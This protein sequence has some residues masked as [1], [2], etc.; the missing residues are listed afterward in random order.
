M[1]QVGVLGIIV[2]SCLVFFVALVFLAVVWN[3][4]LEE[5]KKTLV[6]YWRSHGRHDSFV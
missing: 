2:G 3:N 5:G 4:G 1:Q 6:D